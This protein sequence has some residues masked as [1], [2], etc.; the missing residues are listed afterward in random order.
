M[1][2]SLA[3]PLTV[4]YEAFAPLLL[5]FFKMK[6]PDYLLG[7]EF[8]PLVSWLCREYDIVSYVNNNGVIHAKSAVRGTK[9]TMF[10][11]LRIEVALNNLSYTVEDINES[12]FIK[13]FPNT[14]DF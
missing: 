1:T 8:S 3:I 14:G 13:A 12:E 10:K 11:Y 9:L 7:D 6:R 5:E 2:N 4:I